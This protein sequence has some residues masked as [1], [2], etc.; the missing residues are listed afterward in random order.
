MLEFDTAKL[1]LIGL[2]AL[3]VVGPKDLPRLLRYWGQITAKIRRKASEFQS[4]FLQALGE[5]EVKSVQE[6]LN[7]LHQDVV[8]NTQISSFEKPHSIKS[9][10]EEILEKR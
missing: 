4:H 1:L 10:K 2:V 7:R 8:Q 3:I 5:E 6:D 9:E